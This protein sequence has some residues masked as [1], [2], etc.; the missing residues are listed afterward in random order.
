MTSEFNRNVLWVT[1]VVSFGTTYIFGYNLA[2]LNQP[3]FLIRDFYNE[4]YIRRRGAGVDGNETMSTA[5]ITALWSFTSAVYIPGGIFGALLAGHLAD[6]I[7]R[8]RTVLVSQIFTAVGAVCGTVCVVAGSLE[9]LMISRVIVGV[10][11]GMGVCLA[12]MIIT[13]ISSYSTRGILQGIGQAAISLGIL[14]AGVF[15]LP[16]ILGAS[17]RWTYLILDELAPVLLAVVVL[18]FVPE[19]PRQLQ[20]HLNNNTDTVDDHVDD[21][22][23]MGQLHLD[24][25]HVVKVNHYAGDDD[26]TG[27]KALLARSL[28]FYRRRADVTGEL[29]EMTNIGQ[30]SDSPVRS[31]FTMKQLLMK[32]ELRWPLLVACILQV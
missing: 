7:G 27:S 25:D 30:S 12:P 19:T 17:G 3:S 14:A 31:R 1:V 26:A 15:G 5:T 29:K 4:T 9:L 21:D 8:I 6:R 13:E 2:V 16:T 20:L 24:D 32:K 28:Q 18:P 22:D 11:S 23:R 10:S